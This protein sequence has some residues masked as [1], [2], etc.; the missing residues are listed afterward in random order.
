MVSVRTYH[1]RTMGRKPNREG[2]R[3]RIT[4]TIRP[5]LVKKLD[6]ALE[7]RDLSRS[8]FI[9]Q[10]IEQGLD[11]DQLVAQFMASEEFRRTFA[12]LFA[13]Q[14]FMTQFMLLT[15]GRIPKQQVLAFMKGVDEVA[16]QTLDPPK[17]SDE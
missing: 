17:D 1:T 10:C 8:R 14:N 3:Q 7:G 11:Q 5:D 2:Y 6:A 4:V 16:A 12:S 9:E 15:Q 13:N